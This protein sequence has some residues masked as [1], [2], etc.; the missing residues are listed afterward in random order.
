MDL[1]LRF[2][3]EKPA[4][5][6]SFR[7]IFPVFRLNKIGGHI[8]RIASQSRTWHSEGEALRNKKMPNCYAANDAYKL[9]NQRN[10]LKNLKK[11]YGKTLN[12]ND[13]YGEFNGTFQVANMPRSTSLV[14]TLQTTHIVSSLP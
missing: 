1:N 9:V 8:W 2:A 14:S 12:A 5:V 4:G 10:F 7:N 13:G 6:C 3:S 11:Q